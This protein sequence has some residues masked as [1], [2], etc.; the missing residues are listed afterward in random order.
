MNMILN[1]TDNLG[2][3]VHAFNDPTE[4]SMKTGLFRLNEA[5]PLFGR[6]DDVIVQAEEAHNLKS[7][8][9][10]NVRDLY[11][12]ESGTPPGYDPINIAFPVVSANSDHRLL[13][14]QPF[15]LLR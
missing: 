5:S 7:R 13:S 11:I 2:H 8:L 4:V 9:Q 12:E 3:A 10:V 1:S 6:E 15:G 14:W